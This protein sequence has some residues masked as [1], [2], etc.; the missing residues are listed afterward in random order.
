M[1]VRGCSVFTEMSL[2]SREGIMLDEWPSKDY[3]CVI[4]EM[5]GRPVGDIL[6]ILGIITHIHLSRTI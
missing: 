2:G 4:H 5:F 1:P 3:A 6:D